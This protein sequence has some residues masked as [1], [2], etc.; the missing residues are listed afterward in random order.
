MG[1]RGIHPNTQFVS[2]FEQR[3]ASNR[4]LL[5]ER[6]SAGP[7]ERAQ[8]ARAAVVLCR[9]ILRRALQP[10][11]PGRPPSFTSERREREKQAIDL[12]L[13]CEVKPSP[14]S[15]RRTNPNAKDLVCGN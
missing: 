4:T 11:P 6:A 8:A 9:G 7:V 5:P 14:R 13:G 3:Q 1:A 15:V 12:L 2:R 10:E